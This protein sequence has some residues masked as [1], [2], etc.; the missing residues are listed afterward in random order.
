MN[1][2]VQIERKT[3]QFLGLIVGINHSS[4]IL[5]FRRTLKKIHLRYLIYSLD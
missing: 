2:V 1:K 5:F 3:N 4:F